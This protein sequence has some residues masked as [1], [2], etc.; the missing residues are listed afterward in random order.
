MDSAAQQRSIRVAVRVRPLLPTDGA[1]ETNLLQ[2]SGKKPN[3]VLLTTSGDS[4]TARRYVFDHV[5]GPDVRQVSM[6]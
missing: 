6:D 2:T 3:E 1:T 4:R 5:F